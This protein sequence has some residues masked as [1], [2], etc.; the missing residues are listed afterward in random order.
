MDIQELTPRTARQKQHQDRHVRRRRPRRLAARAGRPDRT[1]NRQDAESRCARRP[2]RLRQQHSGVARHRPGSG[3]GH[4]GLFGYDPIKYL[5]GRGALEATG[6]G[7]ELH[8]G[9][10][11]IR[12]NF[13]TLDAAGNISDRRAGR[14]AT[15][16]SAPLAVKLRDSEDSGR[17]NLR[18]AGEGASLRRRVPRQGPRRPRARHR[19]AAHRRAAARSGRPRIPT[20]RRPPKSPAS[21]SSRRARSSKANRKPTASRSAA[22]PASRTCRATKK[23][24]ASRRPRSPST[25]CTKASPGSSAWTSSAKPKRSTSR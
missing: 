17:R 7:F 21:S 19:S 12:G 11:A 3:P 15:E 8:E 22:S 23:S 24:T 14:I 10:V 2:R 18:R 25:R 6:I 4:L 1:R 13:C 16:E 5:I 20:A 9:D